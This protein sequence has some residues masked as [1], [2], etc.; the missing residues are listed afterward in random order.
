[1]H[2][3]SLGLGMIAQRVQLSGVKKYICWEKNERALDKKGWDVC[4]E[5]KK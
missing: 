5:S 1:M 3:D 2:R 4:V